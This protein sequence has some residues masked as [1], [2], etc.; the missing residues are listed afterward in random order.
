MDTSGIL[1]FVKALPPRRTGT[2]I[3][4]LFLNI[5][6][7]PFIRTLEISSLTEL[8]PMSIAANFRI[9]NFSDFFEK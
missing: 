3:S 8:E 2:R 5:G 1:W 4:E 7:S 6:P 9:S